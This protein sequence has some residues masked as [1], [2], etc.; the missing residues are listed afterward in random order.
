MYALGG[1]VVLCATWNSIT[2]WGK[3]RLLWRWYIYGKG[4]QHTRGQ[5]HLADAECFGAVAI[6]LL[7]GVVH[8]VLAHHSTACTQMGFG[9]PASGHQATCTAPQCH[10]SVIRCPGQHRLVIVHVWELCDT[11]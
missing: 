1:G 6:C 2:Y 3:Q 7:V 8:V 9:W 11:Y 5:Q 4:R 10:L